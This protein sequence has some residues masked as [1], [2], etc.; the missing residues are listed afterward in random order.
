MVRL[1][2]YKKEIYNTKFDIEQENKGTSK[3]LE[4]PLQP[5]N[6]KTIFSY[7]RVPPCP[8]A[9][10]RS[11]L[12]FKKMNLKNCKKGFCIFRFCAFEIRCILFYF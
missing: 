1:K 11:I 6:L 2:F 7:A 9:T 5:L 10:I 12:I 4:M 8:P 3:K